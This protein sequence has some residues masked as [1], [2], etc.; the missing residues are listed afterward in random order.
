MN[1]HNRGPELKMSLWTLVMRE[2]D[3]EEGGYQLEF[4]IEKF[5]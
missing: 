1:E 3:L 4:D 5:G 2:G